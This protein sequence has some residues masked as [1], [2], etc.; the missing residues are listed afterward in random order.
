MTEAIQAALQSVSGR[1]IW[2]VG[3]AV[4][5]WA[6]GRRAKDVDVITGDDVPELGRALAATAGGHFFVMHPLSQTARVVLPDAAWIDIVPMPYGLDADLVRR[7]FTVNAMAMPLADYL[8][9]S[10]PDVGAAT[11]AFVSDPTGGWRDLAACTV[12]ATGPTAMTDDP[13]RVMRGLRLVST[14]PGFQFDEG[15]LDLIRD[16][17]PLLSHTSSERRR[18]EWLQ[19][20]D[21]PDGG[22]AVALAVELGILDQVMPEWRT[23]VGITQNPYHHLDVWGHTLDVLRAFDAVITGGE[24]DTEMPDDLRAPMRQY[25]AEC[26]TQPHTRRSLLRMAILLHDVGKPA[27]RTEDDEGRIRFLGHERD[28]ED[29]TR[30]WAARYRLSGR[31]RAFLASTVGLHMRPG[32][33]MSP[34]VGTR[35]VRRFYRDAG[36]AAPAILLLNIA[37]RLAARGPWTTEDEVTSQVEGSWRIL[38]D[39]LEMRDTVALPLPI[40]GRDVMQ[41]FGLAPGP[42]IGRIIQELRDLHAEEPFPD[43]ESALEAAGRIQGSGFGIQDSGSDTHLEPSV[44][45][46]Y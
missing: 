45:P 21:S 41:A 1:P 4:R 13:V 3:G 12:R 9:H 18:D 16:A 23:M 2:V 46:E 33:L 35:A 31:E 36:H 7:D 44:L 38:R 17:V 22:A 6:L 19:T 14:I 40:S 29:A 26:E 20:M 8:S 27:T 28:S 42:A 15:T 10:S 43:R 34:D 25:L 30:A 5:D 39:W 24:P 37:D 32:G 11:P